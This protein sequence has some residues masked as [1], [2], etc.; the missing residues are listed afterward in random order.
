MVEL[1]QQDEGEQLVEMSLE[2]LGEIGESFQKGCTHL[3]YGRHLAARA[4]EDASTELLER[5]AVQLQRAYGAFLDL[6]ARVLAARAALERAI[7]EARFQRFEEAAAY[8]SKARQVLPPGVD[9]ELEEKLENLG[10]ELE[11]AFAERWSSTEDVLTSLKEMKR[12]FQGASDTDAVIDELIRLA[13]T[14]SGSSR[15]C[16]AYASEDGIEV[17]ATFGWKPQAGGPAP[18]GD[19]SG[20]GLGAPGEPS[21]LGGHRGRR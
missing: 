7:L 6:D 18:G 19:G 5:A 10:K 4:L 15:G 1:G 11:D 12:L 16:V 3:A 8:R 17:V 21:D 13:V 14:R 20:A 9:P 2:S